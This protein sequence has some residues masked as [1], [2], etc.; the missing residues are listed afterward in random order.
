M[1]AITTQAQ[2]PGEIAGPGLAIKVE[3]RNDSDAPIDISSLVVTLYDSTG[4]PAGEI[5]SG[6]DLVRGTMAPGER[7]A[8]TYQFTI[9][10][11]NRS[12]VTIEVSLPERPELL[13]FEGEAPTA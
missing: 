3:L 11:E 10:V 12:P 7:L 9:P 1:A 5:S 8:G 6:S 4:A 2:I 13:V